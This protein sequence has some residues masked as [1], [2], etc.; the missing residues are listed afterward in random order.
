MQTQAGLRG[1][2]E[3]EREKASTLGIKNLKS[4]QLKVA[5]MTTRKTDLDGWIIC[6]GGRAKTGEYN[7]GHMKLIGLKKKVGN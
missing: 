6:T 3:R 7:R 5:H 4:S 1:E 2:R